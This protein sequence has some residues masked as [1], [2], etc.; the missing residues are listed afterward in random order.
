MTE[1]P[2]S[3]TRPSGGDYSIAV[4]L[5]FGPPFMLLAAG[6]IGS[7]YVYAVYAGVR[8]HLLGEPERSE[9]VE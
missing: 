5:V 6:I 7:T 3:G 2:A 1:M 4:L 8:V 9:F